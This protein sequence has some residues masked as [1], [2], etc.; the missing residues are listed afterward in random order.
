MLTVLHQLPE[1]LISREA[2][3]LHEILDGPTLIHLPGRRPQPLLV[4]VLLH[5][6]EDT[7]WQ[8]VRRLLH[9]YVGREL[10]RALSLFVG[11]V[12]AAKHRVRFLNGQPDFNRIWKP[13]VAG[14]P[15]PEH[16][17][18]Q[19]VKQEMRERDVFASVD[20]HNNTGINPHYACVNRLDHR[21]Y[22]L[23]ALFSRT[24][25]YFITPDTVQSVAFAEIC[26]AVTVECGQPG[27]SHGVE[28]AMEYIDACL[29]LSQIPEHPVAPHDIDLFH[30]VAIAKV[31]EHISF[32]FG[33]EEGDI[34]FVDDLELMNFRE[35]PA[36]TTLGWAESVAQARIEVWDEKGQEVSERYFTFDNGELRTKLAVM[37]SMLTINVNAI[38]QDCLCYLMERHKGFHGD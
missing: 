18:M 28:H 21:F 10:P 5:G 17:V 29:H 23:A 24:I 19:Q 35:L 22:H 7:G 26:P 32:S 27:Q 3:Q 16:L 8:A 38:R 6:N 30:T 1:G 14:E 31:P 15:T 4:S 25:V 11:N 2:D 9:N 33:Q 13:P 37:P 36:G 12:R 34:R 20:V